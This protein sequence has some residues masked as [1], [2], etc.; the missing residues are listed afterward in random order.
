MRSFKNTGTSTKQNY[1]NPSVYPKNAMLPKKLPDIAGRY[2][3]DSAADTSP[4]NFGDHGL[5][6]PFEGRDRVLHALDLAPEPLPDPSG[7]AG[8]GAGDAAEGG[9]VDAGAEVVAAAGEDDDS[10]GGVLVEKR[11]G[12]W[13]FGEEIQGESVAERGAIEEEVEDRE[14]WGFLDDF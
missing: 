1:K 6:A 10:D 4:M 7:V 5:P 14:V 13:E 11:E 9:D 12:F 8:G 2:D 3:I